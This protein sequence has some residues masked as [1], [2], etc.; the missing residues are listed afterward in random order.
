MKKLVVLSLL[1]VLFTI[2][3]AEAQRPNRPRGGNFGNCVIPGL[4]DSQ[5]EIID[6]SRL[7]HTKYA[8]DMRNRIAEKEAALRVVTQSDKPDQKK[9]DGLLDEIY[10]LRLQLAKSRTS[11]QM[12]VREQLNDEQKVYFDSRNRNAGSLNR[13]NTF[14]GCLNG[15][16]RSGFQGRGGMNRFN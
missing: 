13:N 9:A 6:A 1:V 4:T 11:H 7:A 3:L 10:A 5:K 12:E 16:S 14:P 15:A 8:L 2:H